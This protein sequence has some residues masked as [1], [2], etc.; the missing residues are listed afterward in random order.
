MSETPLTT[1]KGSTFDLMSKATE[2]LSSGLSSAVSVGGK[3]VVARALNAMGLPTAKDQL[4]N[5]I[6]QINQQLDIIT[7]NTEEI[8]FQL[9]Q[10]DKKLDIQTSKIIISLGFDSIEEYLSNI[11]AGM[12]RF[13]GL[14]DSGGE[15]TDC[16]RFSIFQTGTT[17]SATPLKKTGAASADKGG[18]AKKGEVEIKQFALNTVGSGGIGDQMTK[19]VNALLESTGNPGFLN[20][21]A[22]YAIK[23]M[24]ADKGMKDGPA[25]YSHSTLESWVSWV[26]RIFIEIMTDFSYGMLLMVNAKDY[27]N[28]DMESEGK[29]GLDWLDRIYRPW[30]EKLVEQYK[31]VIERLVLSQFEPL[32]ESV[33]P[34]FGTNPELTRMFAPVDLLCWQLLKKNENEMSPGIVGRQYLRSSQVNRETPGLTLKP[35]DEYEESNG[36]LVSIP[37][38]YGG[39]ST[40]SMPYWYKVVDFHATNNNYHL[41][42][43]RDSDVRIVRYE[44]RFKGTPPAVGG[45]IGTGDSLKLTVNR[46]DCSTLQPTEEEGPNTVVWA[47]FTTGNYITHNQLFTNAS[48][49]YSYDE[50]RDKGLWEKEEGIDPNEAD[51]ADVLFGKKQTSYFANG[52]DHSM[53]FDGEVL[54]VSNLLNW[55]GAA[56]HFMIFKR[57]FKYLDGDG[58]RIHI[59]Y[60][61][62]YGPDPEFDGHGKPSKYLDHTATNYYPPVEVSFQMNVASFKSLDDNRIY[63]N[64]ELLSF[65]HK[66]FKDGSSEPGHDH[67]VKTINLFGSLRYVIQWRS[68]TLAER[69]NL[70]Q[71]YLGTVKVKHSQK[72]NYVRLAW[73]WPELV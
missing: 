67:G 35:S 56:R 53:H 30:M 22:D 51:D 2:A 47:P 42:L 55:K 65:Y 48:H 49:I 7:E 36:A 54:S 33:E 57:L 17:T 66:K 14:I 73:P 59:I 37:F 18:E 5:A 23:R 64:T 44:W 39:G 43:F 20:N 50:R 26:S 25:V 12:T 27:L 1:Q 28:D 19:I 68:D 16:T 3:W 10:I 32:A 46:Y 45:S 29:E 72:V 58:E 63:H 31:G 24:A 41:V 60:D 61:V 69:Q 11:E 40:S 4:K 21:L 34:G 9:N 8:L 52:G 71:G 6:K 15:H 70:G 62:D 13:C 38:N